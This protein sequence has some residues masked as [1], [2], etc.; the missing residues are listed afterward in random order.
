VLLFP[1]GTSTDGS[2][3]L[4]FHTSLFE[5]AVKAGALITPAAV[6]YVI[7]GGVP[8]RELCWYGDVPFLPHLWKALGTPGFSAR[9]AFGN[10]ATYADRREAARAVHAQVSDLRGITAAHDDGPIRSQLIR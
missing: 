1:E 3:L 7:E 10:S 8:E 2:R 4:P 6:R 5:P 9:V